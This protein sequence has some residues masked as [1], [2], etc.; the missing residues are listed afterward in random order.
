MIITVS[1]QKGGTGKSTTAAALATGAAFKGKKALA[2]D[3]DPQSNLTFIM[4]GN[5]ADAGAYELITGKLQPSQVIQHT[6]QG[7]VIAASISLAGADTLLTGNNRIF[8]LREAIKPIVRR[9]D[10]IVIDTPPTLG[11]LLMNALAASDSVIIPLQADILSLQGLYHLQQTIKKIQTD[12]NKRLGISGILFTKHSG[13]TLIA[14]EIV[15]TMTQKAAAMGIPVLKTTIREG[16][17][18]KEAQTMRSSLFEYAPKSKPAKDYLQ[19]LD[20]LNI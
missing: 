15:D 17:A 19:L 3:L 6:A 14:R 13:R 20:E 16:V 5:Q 2:I 8:A 10:L 12:F 7:D 18:V 4:G 9:Y 1:N 11:T